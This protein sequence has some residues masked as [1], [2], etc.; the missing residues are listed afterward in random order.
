[1]WVCSCLEKKNLI[2]EGLLLEGNLSSQTVPI[3]QKECPKTKQEMC[4]SE[5][6]K[7]ETDG[8]G[9]KAANLWLE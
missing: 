9:E 7:K 6:D 5:G 1:M 3:H 2:K 8:R 4:L